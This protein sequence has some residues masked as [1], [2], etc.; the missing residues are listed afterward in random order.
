M[1]LFLH[2]SLLLGEL[3]LISCG[4]KGVTFCVKPTENSSCLSDRDCQRCETLQHYFDNVEETI[5]QNDNVT[6][7]FMSG[8]HHICMNVVSIT[9]KAEVTKMIANYNVTVKDVC[10]RNDSSCHLEFS[11]RNATLFVEN[12]TFVD[13]SIGLPVDSTV[14]DLDVNA[15]N[16]VLKG[17][18]FYRSKFPIFKTLS[19]E[20]CVFQHVSFYI[21]CTTKCKN[22]SFS[23]SFLDVFWATT[24]LL[25]EDCHICDSHLDIDESNVT[26]AGNSYISSSSTAE[27]KFYI[28]SGNI[29]LSGNVSFAKSIG[30]YGGGMYLYLSTLN[31]TAGANVTFIDNTAL[32]QGG[33]IYLSSSKVYIADGAKINFVNNSA[34]DKGGAIYVNPGVTVASV[35]DSRISKCF[36]QS[37]GNFTLYFA[38]NRAAKGGDDVY[39]TSLSACSINNHSSGISAVSSDPI[40]VCLCE[41]PVK[42][43]CN[44]SKSEPSN[45]A[46]FYPGERFTVPILLVGVDYGITTGVVYSNILHSQDS[47]SVK[48]DQSNAENGQMIDNVK[49]CTNLSHSISVLHH[50]LENNITFTMY[51]SPINFTTR[52]FQILNDESSTIKCDNGYCYGPSLIPTFFTITLLPCPPGFTLVSGHCD[53]YLHHVVFDNCTIVN[54]TGLFSWSSNAWAAIYTG[55]EGIFYNTHCSLDF[56]KIINQSLNLV[57]DSNTR[58]AFNRNGTLCG[59]CRENYSLAIGSSHC[60]QCHNSNGVALVIF[61]AAAGFILV[62]FIIALNLTVSQGM[63]NGLI[64]YANIVWTYQ[65]IFFFPRQEQNSVLKFFY[66]FIAWVNLDFGI[67]TCFINGLTGFWKTWLQFV[68][69]FYIWGVAGLIIFASRYSTRLTNLLGNRAIHVLDTLFLLSYMKLLRLIERTMEFSYLK[70]TDQNSTVIHSV[71]WSVDGNLTYFGYPHILL[72]LAVLATL[73]VLCLPYTMLLFL[74]QWL[75]RLPHFKLTNWIMKYH[76]VYDAYFAPLK[77]KHQYWFGVLLLARVILLMTFMSAFAIPQYINLLIIVVVSV[78]ILGYTSVVQPFKNTI[79]L[80]LQNAYISNLV[81][82]AGFVLAAIL[83]N[84]TTL[85]TVAVGLSTGVAFVQFCGIVLYNVVLVIKWRCQYV[86]CCKQGRSSTQEDDINDFLDGYD[87]YTD[88]AKPL[89]DSVRNVNSTATY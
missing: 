77:H 56:C 29:T 57:N 70:Y 44:Y 81:L 17:C 86:G 82:L 40:R 38:D 50:S 46:K 20:D 10:C 15:K 88:E 37:V 64:F 27:I 74:M 53:C 13:Y 79:N 80:I 19:V 9:V 89:V 41:S 69:P 68:F 62:F 34:G 76:P 48:L 54:G 2:L 59:G 12:I 32:L 26:I 21:G 35:I 71:V 23:N 16:V 60:I 85:H 30:V 87:R 24:K 45:Y 66:V 18:S 78:A 7:A 84:K 6:L 33:A 58:C 61:F 67:E 31:V 14:A 43:Q 65:R 5:N 73:V 52:Q 55:Y 47:I 51:I 4:A 3:F 28:Y 83:T 49:Q 25:L 8:M 75:R 39:G 1:N 11:H 42:P 22:C 72:F 63:V 36:Y